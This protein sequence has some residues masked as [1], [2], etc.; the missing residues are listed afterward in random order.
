M[1]QTQAGDQ[2]PQA[3]LEIAVFPGHPFGQRPKG[4][5]PVQQVPLWL[6]VAVVIVWALILL[7]A[8]VKLF[9]RTE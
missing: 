3:A 9:T 4:W 1:P 2:Q 8:S 6:Q 7:F 5:P